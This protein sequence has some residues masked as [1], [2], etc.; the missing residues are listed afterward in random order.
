MKEGTQFHDNLGHTAQVQHMGVWT[1]NVQPKKVWTNYGPAR[2]TTRT[3]FQ[4]LRGGGGGHTRIGPSR[5]PWRGDQLVK[6][7]RNKIFP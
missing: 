1:N 4:N 6:L 7:A 2:H 5:P 3:T